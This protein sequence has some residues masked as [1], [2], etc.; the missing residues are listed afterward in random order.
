M[1][2]GDDDGLNSALYFT[3]DCVKEDRIRSIGKKTHSQDDY[4]D[5]QRR[6]IWVQHL[7][8]H[9]HVSPLTKTQKTNLFMRAESASVSY[10]DLFDRIHEYKRAPA[11]KPPTKPTISRK[12]K[13]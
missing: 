6:S 13:Q 8:D 9:L 11:P 10:N 1:T 4:L 2:L 5:V 12:R 7:R 3:G